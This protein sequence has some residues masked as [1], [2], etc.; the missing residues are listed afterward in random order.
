MEFSIEGDDYYPWQKNLFLGKPF[1][2]DDGQ[3]TISDLPGWGI[4]FDPEWL[5]RS[6]YQQS[7]L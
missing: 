1:H 5:R 4:E 3:V 6:K 2:V 7:E